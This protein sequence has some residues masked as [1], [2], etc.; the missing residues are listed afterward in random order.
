VSECDREASI[1]R[2]PWPTRGCRAMEKHYTSLYGGNVDCHGKHLAD[3]IVTLCKSET[4]HFQNNCYFYI[5]TAVSLPYVNLRPK[6]SEESSASILKA[7]KI[8]AAIISRSVPCQ[9]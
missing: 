8:S 3:I 6:V 1:M 7:E 4:V 5:F 9:H 2:R